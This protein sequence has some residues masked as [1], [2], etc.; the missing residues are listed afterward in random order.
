[1]HLKVNFDSFID[2]VK[3]GDI[4]FDPALNQ[5]NPRPYS[6]WRAKYVDHK[7]GLTYHLLH[8]HQG[9]YRFLMLNM[10]PQIFTHTFNIFDIR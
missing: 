6:Q 10:N 3:N 8:A 4:Y 9:H 1:M 2:G 5:G 7:Y